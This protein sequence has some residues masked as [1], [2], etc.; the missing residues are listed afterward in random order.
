[1]T[2]TAVAGPQGLMA[3]EALTGVAAAA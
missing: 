3:I 2:N 1:M